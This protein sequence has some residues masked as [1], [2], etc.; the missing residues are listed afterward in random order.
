MTTKAD[1]A[2]AVYQRMGLAKNDCAATVDLVMETIRQRLEQGETVK[3]SGFGNL[4]VNEKN[5]RQGRN[6]KTGEPIVVTARRV[7]TFKPS[8]IL[9]DKVNGGAG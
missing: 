9:R 1:L 7:V 8:Q 3:L 4:V 2:E 6:P 5:A